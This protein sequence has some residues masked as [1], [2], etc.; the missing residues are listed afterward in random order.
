[1]RLD[2]TARRTRIVRRAVSFACGVL[3]LAGCSLAQA[4]GDAA[5]GA[6]K[7]SACASCHGTPEHLPLP[8]MPTLAGQQAE[9]LVLQ[10]FL[11]REGLREV[12]QMAGLL[13]GFSD[14]DLEDVA[15]HFAAQ[16]P[17]PDR[18]TRDPRLYARGKDLAQAMACGSCHLKDFRGQRQIPRISHQREDYL[19]ATLRD[20]RDDRRTGADTNMNAL[21]YKVSDGDIRAL[22][23]YLAYQ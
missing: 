4:R 12:P 16:S 7:A 11:M 21:M 18:G 9:F 20:Y 13:K 19:A 5:R 1:M 17:L 10:M 15:A 6:P 8:G 14:R 2:C 22:A 23:H 3:V